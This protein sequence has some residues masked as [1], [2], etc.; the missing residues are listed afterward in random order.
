MY[1]LKLFTILS[2][3]QCQKAQRTKMRFIQLYSGVVPLG[4]IIIILYL[5]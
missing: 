5:I 4:Y 3:K 2:N 1:V